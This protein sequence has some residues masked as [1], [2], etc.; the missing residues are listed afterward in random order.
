MADE[1]P[2]E[3]GIDV[4]RL[5]AADVRSFAASTAALINSFDK[6]FTAIIEIDRPDC[7]TLLRLMIAQLAICLDFR[8][9]TFTAHHSWVIYSKATNYGLPCR[10]SLYLLLCRAEI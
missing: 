7:V 4:Q 10:Q 8:F 9:E 3:T 6:P 5:I 2:T 1:E